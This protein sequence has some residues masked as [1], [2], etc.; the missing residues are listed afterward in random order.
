MSTHNLIML[1]RSSYN[2]MA[3]MALYRSPESCHVIHSI[4]KK[5]A[6]H[7]V[8]VTLTMTSTLRS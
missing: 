1:L 7:K 4:A 5:D 6:V 2:K 3:M 8:M